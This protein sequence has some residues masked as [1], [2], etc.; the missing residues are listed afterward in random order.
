MVGKMLLSRLS[1]NRFL[2]I[3]EFL[4]EVS[5]CGQG[6]DILFFSFKIA[7][8]THTVKRV[9]VIVPECNTNVDLGLKRKN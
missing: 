4:H 1:L 5:H 3:R 2:S 7:F 9:F 6:S 8:N